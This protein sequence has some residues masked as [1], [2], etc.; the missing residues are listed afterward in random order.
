MAA[1]AVSPG[2]MTLGGPLLK[3]MP[4]WDGSAW[5]V[6]VVDASGYSSHGALAFES[7]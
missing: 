2:A 4:R 6:E 3:G 7:S 5:I 1:V